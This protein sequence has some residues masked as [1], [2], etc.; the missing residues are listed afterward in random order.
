M[1]GLWGRKLGAFSEYFRFVLDNQAKVIAVIPGVVAPLNVLLALSAAAFRSPG[2]EFLAVLY[3]IT[4]V[5]L[6]IVM[7]VAISQYVGDMNSGSYALFLSQP[8]SRVA[9]VSAWAL[10]SVVVPVASYLLSLAAPIAVIDVRLLGW[11]RLEDFAML[12]V[13]SLELGLLV[14]TLATLTR[15]ALFS[16][17]VGFL[18][19]VAPLFASLTAT[20][21]LG[22]APM[23]PQVIQLPPA[24]LTLLVAAFA[25]RPFTLRLALGRYLQ[26]VFQ[27]YEALLGLAPL[28]VLLA[29]LTLMVAYAERRFEVR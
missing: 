27:G 5:A 9:Y 21:T 20:V 1:K 4:G 17:G 2:P 24:T 10:S 16:L 11:V 22:G 3:S 6:L 26:A 8:I 7:F 15:S 13:E 12:L 29:S 18:L 19:Y 25:L 28:A 23:P 14:F